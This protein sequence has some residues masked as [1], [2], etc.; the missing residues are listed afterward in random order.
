[1]NTGESNKTEGYGETQPHPEGAKTCNPWLSNDGS[2]DIDP[3]IR[4]SN[5]LLPRTELT[6]VDDYVILQGSDYH[7]VER[8]W[9]YCLGAF[10]A[11]GFLAKKP[12]NES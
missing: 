9:G 7:P 12:P 4:K 11:E 5:L 10:M 8:A 1:M 6:I 3:V 2:F